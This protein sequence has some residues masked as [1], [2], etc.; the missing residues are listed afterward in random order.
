VTKRASLSFSQKKS[1]RKVK[2]FIFLVILGILVGAVSKYVLTTPYFRI[3][4]IVVEGNN[5]LS[6]NQILEWANIPLERSIFRVDIKEVTQRI[7]SKSQ[8][9]EVEIRRVLPAKILIL[10]KERLPF[11]CLSRKEGFFEIGEDGVII[12][13]VGNPMTLPVI[14]VANSSSLEKKLKIGVKILHKAEQSGLS[15]SEID[16]KS[17]DVLVGFLKGGVKIYLGKG[18]HLDYLSYLSS[19]LEISRKEGKEIKYIDLRFDNQVI[20]GEE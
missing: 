10:V 14:K 9:K 12:K 19:I 8:I 5:R 4:E 2:I 11:A 6:S 7:S 15:F 18:E 13:R 3:K 16:I 20:V 1:R 17:E